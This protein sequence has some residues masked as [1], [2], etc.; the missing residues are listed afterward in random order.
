[1]FLQGR[2]RQFPE[3]FPGMFL[4]TIFMYHARAYR[5]ARMASILQFIR[6]DR[7]DFDDNLTRIMGEAFDAACKTLPDSGQPDLVREIIAKRIIEAVKKGERNPLR[8]RNRALAALGIDQ[9]AG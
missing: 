6:Q 7:S 4:G 8:L 9:Q 5:G 2:L 1:M 3:T